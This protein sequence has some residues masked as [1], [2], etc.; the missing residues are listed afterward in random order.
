MTNITQSPSERITDVVTSWP[1][2]S[3]AT[4]ERGE[5]SFRLGRRELGHL[6]GD[7]VLH[8]SFPKKVWHVLHDEGRIDFHPVF[9]G[10]PGNGARAITG[11]ED[12]R[13]VIALLR[14]NYERAVDRDASL[15]AGGPMPRE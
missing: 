9:P 4:G 10:A 6:H 11:E 3:A 15:L 8:I 7:R 2:V 1:G 12:V 5:W 13:D 14:L